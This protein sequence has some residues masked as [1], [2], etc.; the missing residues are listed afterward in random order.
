MLRFWETEFS[1]LKPGKSKSGHR[2]YSRADVALVLKI[3]DLLYEE[4]YTIPGARKVLRK[5]GG[6]SAKP[7][8]PARTQGLLS[9]VQKDL[10]ELLDVFHE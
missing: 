8:V 3:R 2:L 5:R 10:Q 7:E 4:G 6:R 1:E 9:R